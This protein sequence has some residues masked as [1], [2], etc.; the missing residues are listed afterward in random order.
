MTLLRETWR[1]GESV[2]GIVSFVGSSIPC[3][4]VSFQLSQISLFLEN[5]EV[6]ELPYA[7]RSK[8][9]MIKQTKRVYAEFHKNVLNAKRANISL[10]LPTSASADVNTSLAVISWNLRIEFIT[11]VREVLLDQTGP[12]GN[13]VH[14]SAVEIADVEAFDC[15]VP[16]KVYGT[17][18]GDAQKEFTFEI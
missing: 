7:T 17:L 2:T 16:L 11:G 12:S 14:Y 3:Y 18:I 15:V 8:Q 5:T 4:Q 1:L 10:S 6:I 9:E 13:F